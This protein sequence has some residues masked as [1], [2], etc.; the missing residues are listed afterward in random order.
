MNWML[1]AEWLL[2]CVEN[3]E[4]KRVKL[5]QPEQKLKL[6]KQELKQQK[7]VDFKEHKFFQTSKKKVKAKSF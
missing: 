3:A 7:N 6:D 5:K 2:K 1:S 4:I